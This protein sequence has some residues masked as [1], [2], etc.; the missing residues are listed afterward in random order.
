MKSPATYYERK[1]ELIK[2]KQ[3][4]T[5]L[6]TVNGRTLYGLKKR[7]HTVYCEFCG[8]RLSR[9]GKPLKLNYHHWIPEQPAVGL[10]LCNRCHTF[11]EFFD[12]NNVF[13]LAERYSMLQRYAKEQY[14]EKG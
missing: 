12:D 9:M 6:T 7:P 5:K 2:A 1:K 4:Q 8:N 3:R 13:I 14:H 10:W 11:A